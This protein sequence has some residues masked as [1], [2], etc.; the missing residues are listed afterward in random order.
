MDLYGTVS[1]CLACH[2]II[3]EEDRSTC[4]FCGADQEET[5]QK[6]I[7]LAEEHARNPLLARKNPM[8]LNAFQDA[9]CPTCKVVVKAGAGRC[10]FCLHFMLPPAKEIVTSGKRGYW[11]AAASVAATTFVWMSIARGNLVAAYLCFFVSIITAF[12]THGEMPDN[13]LGLLVI[14]WSALAMIVLVAVSIVGA[15][16]G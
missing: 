4:R 9:N 10:P 11:Y 6:L 14:V 12:I 5:R 7:A 8:P 15:F 1:Y 16:G 3:R 2:R 13:R